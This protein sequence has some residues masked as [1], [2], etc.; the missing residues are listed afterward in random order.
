MHQSLAG[1]PHGWRAAQGHFFST[2]LVEQEVA[3]VVLAAGASTRMG[4]TKVLLSLGSGTVLSTV[5]E[6]VLRAPVDRVEAEDVGDG[7]VEPRLLAREQIAAEGRLE[8]LRE[9]R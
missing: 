3:A 4:R 9:R 8:P 2:L 5:M 7:P 1:S 6:S